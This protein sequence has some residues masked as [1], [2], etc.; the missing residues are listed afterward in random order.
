MGQGLEDMGERGQAFR[1]LSAVARVGKTEVCDTPS[2]TSALGVSEW[3]GSLSFGGGQRGSIA[4]HKTRCS[5]TQPCMNMYLCGA[6]QCTETGQSCA[7]AMQR[8]SQ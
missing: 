4:E 8:A 2:S 5:K 6:Q 3:V 1:G 7:A